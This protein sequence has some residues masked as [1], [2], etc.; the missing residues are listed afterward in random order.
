M[1]QISAYYIVVMQIPALHPAKCAQ[2]HNCIIVKGKSCKMVISVK[3]KNK[4]KMLLFAE[5]VAEYNKT[6][7]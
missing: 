1:V 6:D 4:M 7:L 3:N 2:F 5:N